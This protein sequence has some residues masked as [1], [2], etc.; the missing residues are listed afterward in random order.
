MRYRHYKYDCDRVVYNVGGQGL[1]MLL[2]STEEEEEGKIVGQIALHDAST[3]AN[4]CASARVSDDGEIFHYLGIA[5]C[6]TSRTK[7]W[8]DSPGYIAAASEKMRNVTFVPSSVATVF[9]PIG[10][11]P[12]VDLLS[13][14]PPKAKGDA[15][16]E[17]LT[18]AFG[19]QEACSTLCS[20]RETPVILP[21]KTNTEYIS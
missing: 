2:G 13:H 19:M 4:A 6:F 12:P 9:Y 11:T 18:L 17:I 3:V 1:E 7:S 21:P 10:N 20:A 8:E 14:Q 15:L 16:A 5:S